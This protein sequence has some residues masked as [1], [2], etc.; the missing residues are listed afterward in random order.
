MNCLESIADHVSSTLELRVAVTNV[1]DFTAAFL[2]KKMIPT[3]AYENFLVFYVTPLSTKIPTEP[4]FYLQQRLNMQLLG[5]PDLSSLGNGTSTEM[6]VFRISNLYPN[7]YSTEIVQ[8]ITAARAAPVEMV[9]TFEQ[10]ISKSQALDL[11][12]TG[13]KFEI[14]YPALEFFFLM[15]L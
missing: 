13:T 6:V 12:T 14:L 15:H 2:K 7:T 11:E 5:T 3:G 10:Y 8:H 4:V 1:V 9:T